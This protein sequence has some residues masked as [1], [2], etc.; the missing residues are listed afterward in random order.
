MREMS[1]ASLYQTAATDIV[2]TIIS[3]NVREAYEH[4]CIQLKG[5]LPVGTR[6]RQTYTLLVALGANVQLVYIVFPGDDRQGGHVEKQ[7]V[8]DHAGDRFDRVA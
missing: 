2:A 6:S 3:V 7:T 1:K 8:L 5:A 4:S